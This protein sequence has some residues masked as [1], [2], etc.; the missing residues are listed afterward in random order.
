MTLQHVID[1]ALGDVRI[2]CG[3]SIT[4][5]DVIDHRQGSHQLGAGA[6]G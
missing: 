1:E 4:K 3:L 2:G 5:D 6:L